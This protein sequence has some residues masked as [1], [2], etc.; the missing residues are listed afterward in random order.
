MSNKKQPPTK[1]DR[2]RRQLLDAAAKVF[3]ARGVDAASIQEIA[4]MA[5][6]ANGTFYNYFATKEAIL[7]AAAVHYGV[8]LCQ[9]IDAS[10]VQVEDGAER[11]S[12]GGRNYML[13]A[14]EQPDLARFLMSVAVASPIWDEQIRPYITRDLLLGIKQQRFHVA[15]KDAAMTMIMG[16]NMAAIRSILAGKAG[17]SHVVAVSATILRGLGMSPKEAD[18][19]ARRPLPPLPPASE[20]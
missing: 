6:V 18:E 8:S 11:M 3:A 13:L 15:S 20:A 4:A 14:I 5:G 17:R 10:C 16:T 9:R 19:V 12:I 2:T 1:R 7:E